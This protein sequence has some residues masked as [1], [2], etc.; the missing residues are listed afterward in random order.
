MFEIT[1]LGKS[2]GML[3]MPLIKIKSACAKTQNGKYD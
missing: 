1:S 2:N 3:D